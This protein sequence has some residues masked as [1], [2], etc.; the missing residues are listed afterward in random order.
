MPS[1]PNAGKR[2]LELVASGVD[3]VGWGTGGVFE[4]LHAYLPLPLKYL[5][6]NRSIGFEGAGLPFD[7][8]SPDRLLGEDPASTCVVVYS[9]FWRDIEQQVKAMGPFRCVSATQLYA[10]DV[11]VGRIET[12]LGTT[13]LPRERYP[14][15]A[16][17]GILVQ[18]PIEA[19]YTAQVLA[20]YGQRFPQAHLVLSTWDDTA[21]ALVREVETLV[22]E[23]VLS[24]LPSVRGVQ[25]RNC[26]LVSMQRGLDACERSGL[27]SIMKVR[28]DIAVLNHELFDIFKNAVLAAGDGAA[29]NRIMIPQSFTRKYIPYHPSDLVQIGSLEALQRFW[30]QEPDPRDFDMVDVMRQ[31]TLDLLGR[32]RVC[33]ES[34]FGVGHRRNLAEACDGTLA[35]AWRY[36]RDRFVVMDNDTFGLVWMK[37]P[38]LLQNLPLEQQRQTV[39]HAFWRLLQDA[40]IDQLVRLS[41]IRI[42]RGTWYHHAP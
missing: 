16:E 42:D 9:T 38:A 10:D 36:L 31:S 4:L 2:L 3:L 35:D 27:R 1:T 24:P 34:Y 37:H 13:P 32:E 5:V 22:D 23:I 26:Q 28:T 33:A 12:L 40:D 15:R 25:N 41:P 17:S 20:S 19:G 14:V 7:V 11:S 39:D 8:F 30:R 6:D 29:R 21:P 18:G